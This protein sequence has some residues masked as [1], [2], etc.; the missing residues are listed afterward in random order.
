MLSLHARD[1]ER[2]GWI[3]RYIFPVSILFLLS[4][5]IFWIVIYYQLVSAQWLIYFQLTYLAIMTSLSI[6]VL[7]GLARVWGRK[8]V[9]YIL[10]GILLLGLLGG[11]IVHI[12]WPPA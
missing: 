3:H 2:G 4:M 10:V 7:I 6:I 9:I 8:P 1:L 12:F 11:I 5:G